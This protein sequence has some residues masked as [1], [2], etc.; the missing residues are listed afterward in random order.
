MVR[1]QGRFVPWKA[2]PRICGRCPFGI[3]SSFI[4]LWDP[5]GPKGSQRVPFINLYMLFV[6]LTTG[7]F[8]RGRVE[9]GY[10]PT[11][12]LRIFHFYLISRPWDLRKWIPDIWITLSHLYLKLQAFSGQWRARRGFL[13]RE[14]HVPGFVEHAL[15]GF[16]QVSSIVGSQGVPACPI[17]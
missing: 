1:P 12:V 15:S 5:R 14:K 13:F 2:R 6:S 7:G 8:R 4:N 11:C 3:W 16:G 9:N 17:Y 10:W